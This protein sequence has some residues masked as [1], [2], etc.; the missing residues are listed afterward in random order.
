MEQKHMQIKGY[1]LWLHQMVSETMLCIYFWGKLHYVVVR[2]TMYV[3]NDW[4]LCLTH[5]PITD[6]GWSKHKIC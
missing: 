5:N 4:T 6:T 1:P 2:H 3:L